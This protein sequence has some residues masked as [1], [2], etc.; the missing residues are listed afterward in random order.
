MEPLHGVIEFPRKIILNSDSV[1][2]EY[3]S[4]TISNPNF[5]EPLIWY[6]DKE[7]IKN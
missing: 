1:V 4:L 3:K 6:F 7:I 2:P 5:E